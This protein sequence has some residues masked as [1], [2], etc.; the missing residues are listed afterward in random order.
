MVELMLLSW[1]LNLEWIYFHTELSHFMTC[2]REYFVSLTD[3]LGKI[4]SKKPIKT[5]KFS[6]NMWA[7]ILERHLNDRRRN[8]Y[9]R[10]D[11]GKYIFYKIGAIG[12]IQIFRS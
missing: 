5:I 1:V 11:I 10:S 3:S 7:D 4:P 9:H 2:A 12:I 8:D 6:R